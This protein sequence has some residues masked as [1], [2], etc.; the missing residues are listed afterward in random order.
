MGRMSCALVIP[1]L[2]E[3]GAIG[4]VVGGFAALLRSEGEPWLDEIVVADNG[5]VDA[6]A[7]VARR[8]GASV[9][10]APQRGYGNACIAGLAHLAAR[11][12]GPPDVVAFADGDGA[13]VP[14]ELPDLLRPLERGEAELVI[15][16][17]VRRGDDDALTLPQRFGNRFATLLFR[18]LYGVVATDL[19]PFRAIRWGTLVGLGMN[20]RDYGWTMEMQVKAAKAGVRTVE[21]DVSNKA[22]T[23]GQSKVSGTVRGVVGAG[24]KILRTLVVYR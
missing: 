23:A 5:S 9:V 4:E 6:T 17:R 21:V 2:N 16:S 20:D 1:A 18:R 3:E 15:G 22:R 12:G 19:G 13:N 8:A 7:E 11:R 24:Y 14:E 10:P